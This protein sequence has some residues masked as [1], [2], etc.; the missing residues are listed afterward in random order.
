MK[1]RKGSIAFC[2]LG[3]LGLII[4]DKPQLVNYEDGHSGMAYVGIHLTNKIA[5]IRFRWS[6]R[7]PVVVGHVDDFINM[8]RF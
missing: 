4:E 6:S 8:I 2:S 3:C 1:P 7:N 5:P